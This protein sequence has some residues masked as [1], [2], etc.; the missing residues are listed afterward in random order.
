[1]ADPRHGPLPALL[2]LLT[3]LSGV[4]DAVSILSLGR[5]FVANMTGN[6]VVV[7]FAIAG[8]PGFSL[9]AAVAALLGFVAGAFGGGAL[10]QRRGANRGV[11]LRDATAV[12]LLLVVAALVVAALL[13]APFG[14]AARIVLSAFCALAMGVQSATARRIA[15]PDLTTTVVTMTLTGLAA[16]VRSR[17]WSTV[18]RRVLAV[19]AMFGGAAVGTLLVLRADPA[20]AL[21]LVAA[22]LLAVSATVGVLARSSPAWSN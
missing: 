19:L 16:D 22:I 6:V 8:A 17:Q 11:L 12:E 14:P 13:G 3:I 20:W 7:G 4:I 2:L 10:V 21:A 9:S 18:V 15:V 1:V 5:V